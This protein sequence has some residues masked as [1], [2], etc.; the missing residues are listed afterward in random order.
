MHINDLAYTQPLLAGLRRVEWWLGG[1]AEDG[2]LLI[3]A[4]TLTLFRGP[5]AIVADPGV[6]LGSAGRTWMLKQVSLTGGKG[7]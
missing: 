5:C 3:H 1:M 4:L 2:R 6:A 7:G